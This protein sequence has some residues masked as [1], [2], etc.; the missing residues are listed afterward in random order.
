MAGLEFRTTRDLLPKGV[1]LILFSEG[2]RVLAEI[3]GPDDCEDAV[4]VMPEA[5][6]QALKRTIDRNDIVVLDDESLWQEQ[7]GTLHDSRQTP[8][9]GTPRSRQPI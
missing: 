2:D 6:L 1:T 4:W 8:D 7:W 5:I 9:P 3:I